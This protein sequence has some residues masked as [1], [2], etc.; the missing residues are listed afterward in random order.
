VTT[1]LP[2]ALYAQADW[3]AKLKLWPTPHEYMLAEGGLAHSVDGVL[4][5]AQH[6]WQNGDRP[7]WSTV[8]PF[9]GQHPVH[10]N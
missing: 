10:K 6:Q 9:Y 7:H 3:D 2:E 1:V 4:T 8:L 5:L